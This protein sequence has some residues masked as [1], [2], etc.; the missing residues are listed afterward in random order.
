MDSYF[1]PHESDA[2]RAPDP[3]YARI[4]GIFAASSRVPGL[5]TADALLEVWDVADIV[6]SEFE[7]V[8]PRLVLSC[9]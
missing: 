7:S 2:E 9:P 3:V 5:A 1:S 6:V 8:E 4:D